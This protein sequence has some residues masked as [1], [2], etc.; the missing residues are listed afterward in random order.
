MRAASPCTSSSA[1]GALYVFGRN[2]YGQLG[3]RPGAQGYKTEYRTPTF[4]GPFTA[5][6]MGG[7]H[8]AFFAGTAPTLPCRSGAEVFDTKPHLMFEWDGAVPGE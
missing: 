2:E 3:V 5:V 4:A 1:G 8:S 6:V 7:D